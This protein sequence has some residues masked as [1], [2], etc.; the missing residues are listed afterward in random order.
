M[1]SLQYKYVA[2]YQEKASSSYHETINK[3]NVYLGKSVTY[4]DEGKWNNQ[5][6]AL[7]KEWKA[8]KIDLRK[9]V[10]YLENNQSPTILLAI[11]EVRFPNLKKIYLTGNSIESVE[12]LGNIHLPKLEW[13][14]ISTIATI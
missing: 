8:E 13:L 3:K 7:I 5:V 11:K 14:G 6:C 1:G 10:S 9:V 2:Y 4:L 12:G